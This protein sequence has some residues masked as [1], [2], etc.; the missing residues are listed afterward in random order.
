MTNKYSYIDRTGKIVIDVSRYESGSDF[1]DGLA[2]VS[3]PRKGWGFIDKTGSLVIPPKFESTLGF[4]EGLAAV[5]LDD[6]WGFINKDGILVIENQYD[7]VGGF[8]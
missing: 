2:A 6:K 5:V 1:S 8:F 4:R 7:W 3:V